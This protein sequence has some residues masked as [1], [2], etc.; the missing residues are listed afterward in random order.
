M[1]LFIVGLLF[2]LFA[3]SA[4][5]EPQKDIQ[6]KIRSQLEALK[7]D[8]FAT[9]FTFAS[10]S[11]KYMFETP[12]NFGRMVRGGYPMVWRYERFTFLDNKVTPNGRSQDV[13][14]KDL[15]NT[16]HYLRYFMTE[17]P[18]GWKISGVQFLNPSDFSV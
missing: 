11:I 5:A 8:D 14:I 18:Q 13:Q 15:E 12:E 2:S 17:T 10:P 6:T 7:N 1:R 9:A 4:N 3:F 16:T